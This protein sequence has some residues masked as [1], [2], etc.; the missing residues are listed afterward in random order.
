MGL[1]R[2]IREYGEIARETNDKAMM[3]TYRLLNS[4]IVVSVLAFLVGLVSAIKL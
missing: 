1:A 2:N 4:L 3:R